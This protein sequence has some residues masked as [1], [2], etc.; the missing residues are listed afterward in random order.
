MK[1]YFDKASRRLTRRVAMAALAGS[2]VVLAAGATTTA[3]AAEWPTDAVTIVVAYPAGGGT[4]ISIRALTD[5]LSEKLGQPVLVQNVAGAGGGVAATKVAK[6]APD[7]YTLLATNSTSITLAPLVQK[8]LY[9]MDSFEHVAI[10]GEFQNAFF[11]G[12]KQPYDSLDGLIE[13]VKSENRAIKGASQLA[14]DRLVMQY[15]A[16]ERGVEFVPV[17][18][19]GGSGSVQAVMAGDVD[20][21]FSG[22]S[23]APIVKAGD[24]KALFAASYERLKLAPDLI[25]MK[26]LGFPFGVTSHISLHAPAGTPKEIVDKIAAALEPAVQSQPVQNIGEKRFMD[27][28]YRGGD[29]AAAVM[30]KERETYQELVKTVGPTN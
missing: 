26:D 28:T 10:I 19:S 2:A 17:P 21:A 30:N 5:T 25:S 7:G 15:I 3:S 4:D 13:T 22:G 14:I 24:A 1:H 20:V 27:M 16:K 12:T 18:V 9:D 23:W 29:A 8:A 6:A 11:T